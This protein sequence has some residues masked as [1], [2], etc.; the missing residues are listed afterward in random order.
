MPFSV[1]VSTIKVTFFNLALLVISSRPLPTTILS[2]VRSYT[3]VTVTEVPY[4]PLFSTPNTGGKP[5]F[6]VRTVQRAFP[7]ILSSTKSSWK[8]VSSWTR[9]LYVV[10]SVSHTRW[11][12]CCIVT[13]EILIQFYLTDLIGIR[14]GHSVRRFTVFLVNTEIRCFAER[15]SAWLSLIPNILFLSLPIVFVADQ[16]TMLV[17]HVRWTLLFRLQTFTCCFIS[18]EWV[19]PYISCTWL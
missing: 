3:I 16:S 18:A 10:R 19:E 5:V 1:L 6:G 4:I 17:S 7:Y 11:R 14:Y 2:C 12:K 8:V 9:R 15:T 13:C